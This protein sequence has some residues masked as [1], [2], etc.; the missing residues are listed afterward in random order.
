MYLWMNGVLDFLYL[1]LEK[2]SKYLELG[3]LSFVG[4][5]FVNLFLIFDQGAQA[6]SI[7]L[8]IKENQNNSII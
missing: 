3:P 2:M 8:Q 4:K 5:D 6:L 1:I 7:K